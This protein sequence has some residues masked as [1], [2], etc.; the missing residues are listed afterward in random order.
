L[1]AERQTE[2]FLLS[3]DWK[4]MAR[5][6]A[7]AVAAIGGYLSFIPFETSPDLAT[8]LLL[9]FGLL[10]ANQRDR[11]RL[12]LQQVDYLIV[13]AVVLAASLSALL[14]SEP[15]RGLDYLVYL[16]I[17]LFLLLLASVL[18]G[19][20]AAKASAL[21]IGLFGVAHLVSLMIASQSPE[22]TDAKSLIS[23]AGMT[24]LIVPNDALI[25][26]LCL[27]S[28]ALVLLDVNRR[29]TVPAYAILAIY[30]ALSIFVC[31]LLQ[32]KVALLSLLMAVGSLALIRFLLPRRNAAG[33][34]PLPV[35]GILLT[36][37]LLSGGLAWYLGNQSTTRLSIW[38]EASVAH[39]SIQEITFGAGP[40][41]FLFN[42]SAAETMFDKGDLVIPWA[43]N[44]YLEA[45]HDQGLMGLLPLIALTL[46]PILRALRIEDRNVRTM[47]LASMV[48]FILVALLEVTLTRRFYFAFLAFFYGLALA[49]TKE[50][51]N[52]Q[53]N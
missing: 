14:S 3:N 45:W 37:I 43:H 13:A 4:Q 47:I 50:S 36:A 12:G 2:L 42:P 29:W 19:K 1:E 25:L 11:L 53:S 28:L 10:A 35:L 38:I 31:Y 20:S 9:S 18:A 6:Q 44:L 26:G 24:T 22:V 32:S 34:S 8:F 51:R 15:I 52:E 46:L 30:T 33:P 23:Q 7:L 40:N 17:N 16:S 27:P 39:S 49:Q 48:T 21:L 41:T 5:A